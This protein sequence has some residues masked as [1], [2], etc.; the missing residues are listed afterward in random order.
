M[1]RKISR[2]KKRS[3]SERTIQTQAAQGQF[4][5]KP[6]GIEETSEVSQSSPVDLQAQLESARNGFKFAD[7]AISP[8]QNAFPAIQRKVTVGEANDKYE[9]EADQVA[10]E[11]VESI[12]SPNSEDNSGNQGIQNK[13]QSVQRQINPLG[14]K[15]NRPIVPRNDTIERSPINPKGQR[16]SR[17]EKQLYKQ[18]NPLI[19]RLYLQKRSDPDVSQLAV[20][21]SYLQRQEM[22]SEDELHMKPQET[23][24]REEMNE[25]EEVQMKPDGI[26]R[27]EMPEED[28]MVQG[29]DLKGGTV[30]PEF[31]QNLQQAKRGG[32]PLQP[33]VQTKM[34]DAMGADFSEVKVHTDAQS[35]QLNQS[36]QAK[37]FTTGQDLFFR[38]GEYKPDSK[39]GQKLIAHELTH[40]VQQNGKSVN[41]SIEKQQ[42][43]PSGISAFSGSPL[44]QRDTVSIYDVDSNYREVLFELIQKL[45]QNFIDKTVIPDL[46]A[47]GKSRISKKQLGASQ[48]KKKFLPKDTELSQGG[49]QAIKASLNEEEAAEKD[50]SKLASTLVKENLKNNKDNIIVNAY[51]GLENKLAELVGQIVDREFWGVLKKAIKVTLKSTQVVTKQGS[52]TPL[53]KLDVFREERTKQIQDAMDGIWKARRD[54]LKEKLDTKLA[55]KAK[56]YLQADVK[57]EAEKLGAKE[58]EERKSKEED[59]Q[60]IITP[61]KSKIQ[62]QAKALDKEY[63]P[64]IQEYLEYKLGAS[65]AGYFRSKELKAFRQEAK[66]AA[67]AEIKDRIQEALEDKASDKPATKKYLEMKANVK[68]YKLAKQSANAAL[69]SFAQTGTETVF[70]E[71]N[72]VQS[73]EDA[74]RQSIWSVLRIGGKSSKAFQAANEQFFHFSMRY[75]DAIYKA[76][77]AWA[78]KAV[79][80]QQRITTAMEVGQKAAEKAKNVKKDVIEN[81][82]ADSP[83]HSMSILSVLLDKFVPDPGDKASLNVEFNIPIPNSPAYILLGIKGT[84]ARGLSG[85]VNAAPELDADDDR[86][87]VRGDFTFG[88]GAQFLGGKADGSLGVFLRAG[89]ADSIKAAQAMSYGLYRFLAKKKAT[90]KMANWWAGAG[91]SSTGMSKEERAETWAAMVEEQVFSEEGGG[92]IVD[93]GVGA[94]GRAKAAVTQGAEAGVTIGGALFTRYDKGSIGD[95]LGQSPENPEQATERRQN[96]RGQNFQALGVKF[97]GKFPGFGLGA[98]A[99]INCTAAW[100][101]KV[102]KTWEVSISGDLELGSSDQITAVASNLA[103]GILKAIQKLIGL[104]T[105][106]KKTPEKFR[107][108]SSGL[109]SL[110]SIAKGSIPE[111]QK[112]LSTLYK[113]DKSEVKT[114][115]GDTFKAAKTKQPGIPST[116]KVRVTFA[117][118]L[119]KG[120]VDARIS[121]WDVSTT[122]AIIPGLGGVKYEKSRRI[123]SGNAKD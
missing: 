94:R 78:N 12:H 68:G 122:K 26:Q 99:S 90:K 36:I 77:K 93:T 17:E 19:Q 16:I 11:V 104:V 6:F 112:K 30:T 29:N 5:P 88:A 42:Q 108:I 9:Q 121:L 2:K 79:K 96:I 52:A 91:D 46:I 102:L 82:T 57:K 70:Q 97:T 32:Q 115:T 22:E 75:E 55:A 76:A 10:S 106:N 18:S 83:E 56:K 84:A 27:N 53:K 14:K 117:G 49:T 110:G 4:S 107:N 66:N 74:V 119:N 21:P 62:A 98:G 109:N 113:V 25:D 23:I 48:D 118:G 72:T 37:A 31:E 60:K 50:V 95:K 63:Y 103:T 81:I 47:K 59:I 116:K 54:T 123:M 34:G 15:Y 58:L 101:K 28:D 33:E 80:G 39:T 64:K 3:D 8:P 13:E 61:L 92:G 1:S 87:E 85:V 111:M 20:K 100:S 7:I 86:V 44:I 38:Q 105:E 120:K 65:G 73:L 35:D 114:V 41:R 89:A 24:Q 51:K 40:V 69:E 45:P 71:M 43:S 67:Q